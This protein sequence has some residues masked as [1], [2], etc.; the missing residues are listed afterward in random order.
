M[1]IKVLLDTNI[2]VYRESDNVYKE[3]IGELFKII[4]NNPDMYKYIH[5]IIKQELLQNFHNEKRDLLLDRLTS[6]N[7]LNSSR[8]V[9]YKLKTI[10][11]PLNKTDNDQID[12]IILNELYI[13]KVDFL[14]TE[15]KKIKEKSIL[16]GIGHKVMNINEFIFSN[17]AEKSINHNILDIYKVKFGDLD[18]NDPFFDSLKNDYP[19][20]LSWYEKKRQEDVYC[21]KEQNRILGLL[22]LKN[23]EPEL[24]DYS[25]IKPPMKKN[26]K[27]KISTFKVEISGKK[28]GERFM[29]I[30]FDQALFS[31][32]DEIYVTIYD[33]DEKK[34]NLI[35][36]F[37]KFGF[38]Y[39]GKKN[40][41][42]VYIR[43]M[44]KFFDSDYPLKSYPYFKRN[45]DT[46][47]IPIK[48][49]YHTY[50]LPDS[51][52]HR[53]TYNN[54]HMPVEYAIN[55]YYITNCG[56][57][58]IPKIGDNIVFYRSKQEGAI[59]KYSSVL[60]TIGIV[61]NIF[62]P[63]NSQE[64]IDK[65]SGRTVYDENELRI[66]YSKN[67][68][69]IEFAYITTLDKKLNYDFCKA[70]G[71]LDDAPRGVLKIDNIKFQKIL[72]FGKVDT[73]LIIK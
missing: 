47:I 62:I 49:K 61:T 48:P 2:I 65:V 12:D 60:T 40:N 3:R 56:W 43:S 20:F 31:M 34:I 23:E 64:L 26:R 7:V 30:I 15:D 54:I 52:L 25:D 68:Y 72:E 21:Y 17:K 50:L 27:L 10:T 71:I 11:S 63:R 37:E 14:V 55:K 18:I 16:L 4:D 39:Y 6:Y 9:D 13:G 29:K 53:E 8:N 38:Q 51:I 5:P 70:N 35:R 24:E 44:K 32:V 28:I 57:L 58:E 73:S 33:N 66:T 59:A 22:F 46:F 69:V 41:E 19:G 1:M 36:Y 67:T 45:N 42:L